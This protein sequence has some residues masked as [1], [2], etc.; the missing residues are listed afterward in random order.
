MATTT[1]HWASRRD[2]TTISPHG[3]AHLTACGK[4]TLALVC[5][6][7]SHTSGVQRGEHGK[8][9]SQ[10][11]PEGAVLDNPACNVGARRVIV[12]DGVP[13]A[14]ALSASLTSCGKS[15]VIV[16]NGRPEV[17]R[18]DL[19]QRLPFAAG[20]FHSSWQTTP[21]PREGIVAIVPPHTSLL[22]RL[23]GVI[24]RVSLRDKNRVKS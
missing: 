5:Y 16:L 2:A 7:A 11:L 18:D 10:Q 6:M 3:F 24:E 17:C 22:R 4:K 14:R 19:I 8:A 23:C 21:A 20:K 1:R 15:C 12:C 13:E 9:T